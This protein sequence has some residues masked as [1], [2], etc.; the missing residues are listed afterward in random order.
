MPTAPKPVPRLE[1]LLLPLVDLPTLTDRR[2][3]S[4][5][6]PTT[7]AAPQLALCK[8]PEPVGPHELASV[9]AKPAALGQ[10]QVFEIVSV[11]MTPAAAQAALAQATAQARACM[12]YQANGVAY[13]VT[14]LTAT[15]TGLQYRLKTPSVVG[16]D[17]RTLAVSG[18]V[19]VLVTGYGMPPVG[20][21]ILSFQAE[22]M[23]KALTRLR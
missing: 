19:M 20:H 18:H 10:V 2:V 7:Q 17:V 13:Q 21:T 14:D 15:S 3:F 16:G 11:F 4:S 5:D 1:A 22:V 6:V 12:R 9:L 23:R 8:A